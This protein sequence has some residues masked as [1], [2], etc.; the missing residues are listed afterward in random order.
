MSEGSSP[1]GVELPDTRRLQQFVT[2]VEAPTLAAAAAGLFITQQALSAAIRQLEKDIGVQLFSRAQRSLA[3]TPAGR[4]LYTAATP[5]LAGARQ[6]LEATRRAASPQPQAFVIGHTPA[7]SSEEVYRLIDPLIR[8]DPAIAITAQPLYPARIREALLEGTIDVALRRGV[9]TPPDLAVTTI[10]Y[11]TLRVATVSTHP[12]VTGSPVAVRDLAPY[13]VIVW[14]PE[15]HSYY[16]DFLLSHCRRVGFEPHLVVNRVQGTPP[17]T[18]VLTHPDACAF[19]TDEPGPK[20]SGAITIAD[21]TDPPLAPVQMLWLPHT[22][23][24]TRAQ[25]IAVNH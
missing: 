7:I 10:S 16:T 2:A 9:Q 11:N 25:I 23:H 13:P 24:P 1:G 21:F 18:A 17:F 6:L 15:H 4:E 3:L 8:A 12:L 22:T 19:V 20:Y 14:A 5:F